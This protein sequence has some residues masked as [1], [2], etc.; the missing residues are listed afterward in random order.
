MTIYKCDICGVAPATPRLGY[1]FI[2]ERELPSLPE[3]RIVIRTRLAFM[4]HPADFGGPPDLCL[5][6]FKESLEKTLVYLNSH[7]IK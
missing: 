7:S 1:D 6:C 5:N 4:D 2:L 3:C